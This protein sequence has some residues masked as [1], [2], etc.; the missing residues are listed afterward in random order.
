MHLGLFG[1]GI[2]QAAPAI[3]DALARE[4]QVRLATGGGTGQHVARSV[5]NR[6]NP[7][8]LKPVALGNLLEQTGLRLAAVA[9]RIRGVR[10]VK[11]SID[12]TAYRCQ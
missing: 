11:H 3:S 2:W 1:E 6:R 9:T 8:Q 7:G 5:T 12:T 10:A 4:H